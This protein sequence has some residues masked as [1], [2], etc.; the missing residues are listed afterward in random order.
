MEA[1][2]GALVHW[3]ATGTAASSPVHPDRLSR[4]RHLPTTGEGR[5]ASAANSLGCNRVVVRVFNGVCR[6]HARLRRAL[7]IGWERPYGLGV[8]GKHLQLIIRYRI[9]S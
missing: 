7:V 2:R 1:S 4:D 6:A 5:L 9:I 8:E 3:A